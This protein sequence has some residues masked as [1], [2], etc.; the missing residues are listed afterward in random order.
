ML[1]QNER[2]EKL[3]KE[4]VELRELLDRVL[5]ADALLRQRVSKLEGEKDG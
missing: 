2:I 4:L 1:K 5:Y 3:E